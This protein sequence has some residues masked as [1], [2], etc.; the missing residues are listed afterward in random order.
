M[1]S[2]LYNG[3]E[4]ISHDFKPCI[5]EVAGWLIGEKDDCYIVTREIVTQPETD[6]RGTIVIPKVAVISYKTIPDV[7]K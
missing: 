6:A 4:S 5:F 2:N 1:D 3:Q 7:L